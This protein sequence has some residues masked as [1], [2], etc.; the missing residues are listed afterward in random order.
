MTWTGTVYKGQRASAERARVALEGS[1]LTVAGLA[2][3]TRS[4]DLAAAAVTRRHWGLAGGTVL[5]IAGPA[6]ELS[7]GG[8]GHTDP[9]LPYAAGTAV[10]QVAL[11]APDFAAFERALADAGVPGTQGARVFTLWRNPQRPLWAYRPAWMGLLL[12]G[13]LG[14]AGNLPYLPLAIG[15]VALLAG[16]F[17]LVARHFSRLMKQPA[18]SLAF[19][20]DE[21]VVQRLPS[22]GPAVRV[23]RAATTIERF[24]WQ[25]PTGRTGGSVWDFPAVRL[26]LTGDLAVSVGVAAVSP[27]TSGPLRGA[28]AYLI[29][30][31][32]YAALSAAV[33][34][35]PGV[36]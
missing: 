13:L 18:L 33:A 4:W 16:A 5:Q 12:V 11:A 25:P 2:N 23:A 17:A 34:E 27:Q 36:H 24:R 3:E 1:T 28:P 8:A 21:I 32:W 20:G 7:L 15:L 14:V 6:G 29:N 35:R 31:A 10:P 30:P 9:S 22:A 19:P 26:R